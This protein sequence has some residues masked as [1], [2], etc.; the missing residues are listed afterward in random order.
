MPLP[1]PGND[2]DH[3]PWSAPLPAD[4]AERLAALHRLK[5]LDTAP[6]TAFDRVVGMAVDMFQVPIAL[7]S[8]VD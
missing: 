5:I 8:L 7:I 2:A 6:E 1:P 3:G 4:E